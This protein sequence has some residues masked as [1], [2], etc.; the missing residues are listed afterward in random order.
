MLQAYYGAFLCVT[1]F[2]SS[3]SSCYKLHLYCKNI[4][5]NF[6][7]Q[8]KCSVYSSL[9]CFLLQKLA[10]LEALQK[11]ISAID[12]V[13]LNNGRKWRVQV[14]TAIAFYRN[15]LVFYSTRIGKASVVAL[16]QAG[17][18]FSTYTTKLN[19]FLVS[20]RLKNHFKPW[21]ITH[22]RGGGRGGGA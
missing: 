2:L 14:R 11:P 19:L 15:N 22:S 1:S 17:L 13:L 4:P 5:A 12:L 9:R 7:M 21:T 18:P 8:M 20:W 10:C 6:C 16:E 3:L